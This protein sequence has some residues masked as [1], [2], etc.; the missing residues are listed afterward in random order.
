MGVNNQLIKNINF[1]VDMTDYTVA[2]LIMTD[3]DSTRYAVPKKVVNAPESN[4]NM[5]LDMVGFS[6]KLN[7][8]SIAFK[9][10]SDNSNVFLTTEGQTLLMSDKFIQ[11]DFK[12]PS[13]RMYGFGERVRE[14][15]LTEGT[16][17][18]WADGGN[19]PYDDG[20]TGRKQV[21]GVHP[22]ILVQGKQKGDFF[23]MYFR[24]SNAMSPVIKFNSD[25]S[26]ILSYITIGGQIE[27]YFFIHGNAKTIIQMY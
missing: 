22:F 2:R 10:S 12:L 7:P 16:W 18:M 9:D 25:G 4:N 21:Y 11:M 1:A 14:F 17:T 20:S 27:V 5:R 19:S 15:Q 24:N 6:Y 8:F 23:G 3:A 26:S 13:Q